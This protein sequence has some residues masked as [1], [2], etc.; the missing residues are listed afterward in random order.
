MVLFHQIPSFYV[1][2][3]AVPSMES[4]RGDSKSKS[5]IKICS[6]F[7]INDAVLF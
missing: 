2:N 1:I 5:Y 6:Y 3:G 4:N 7:V